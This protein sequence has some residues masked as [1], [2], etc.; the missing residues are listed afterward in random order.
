M[1]KSI[2]FTLLII[3]LLSMLFIFSS[4]GNNQS[5]TLEGTYVYTEVT[6]L[7]DEEGQPE[8][9]KEYKF[10]F[11]PEKVTYFINGMPQLLYNGDY[12]IKGDKISLAYGQVAGEPISMSYSFEL[13]DN[14]IVFDGKK[15][16]KVD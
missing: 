4:C 14:Y 15:Y 8:Y 13:G 5:I 10:V 2:S 3:S 6:I 12:T 7:E 1:K 11:T 16:D 9:E